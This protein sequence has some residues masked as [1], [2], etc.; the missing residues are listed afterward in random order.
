MSG[1]FPSDMA[2]LKAEF[3]EMTFAYAQFAIF[4][5]A[6]AQRRIVVYGFNNVIDLS[7]CGHVD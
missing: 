3:I 6:S 2:P 1:V 5:L 7:R 4:Y